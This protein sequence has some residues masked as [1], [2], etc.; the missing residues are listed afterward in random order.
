MST[1]TTPRA[2]KS[3]GGDVSGSDKDKSIKRPRTG[4]ITP[5]VSKK[6][7][8]TKGKAVESDQANTTTTE[9]EDTEAE[10]NEGLDI[11]EEIMNAMQISDQNARK[12]WADYTMDEDPVE[13]LDI[14][15]AEGLEG[16][17]KKIKKAIPAR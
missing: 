14:S 13:D 1:S 12:D 4:T 17:A 3:G 9:G 6:L 2:N 15:T 7:K 16:F 10:A 8:N 5:A 11:D